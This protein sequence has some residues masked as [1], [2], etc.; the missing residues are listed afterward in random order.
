MSQPDR[1]EAPFGFGELE[2]GSAKLPVKRIEIH[3]MLLRHLTKNGELSLG[4]VIAIAQDMTAALAAIHARGVT[5]R[6]LQ[7]TKFVLS[8]AGRCILVAHAPAPSGTPL[9]VLPIPLRGLGA[10]IP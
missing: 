6:G 10:L 9:P 8:T 1:E 7:P 2:M 5:H 3:A 4:Q